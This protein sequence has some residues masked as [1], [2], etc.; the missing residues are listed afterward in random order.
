MWF[1]ASKYVVYCKYIGISDHT[2]SEPSRVKRVHIP[3][4]IPA[5]TWCSA[6]LTSCRRMSPSLPPL[7]RMCWFQS[8]QP[9]RSL[10]PPILLHGRT[11]EVRYSTSTTSLQ[12]CPYRISFEVATSHNWTLPA[13]SPTPN[14]FP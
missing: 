12:V 14:T 1:S 11:Q 8:R 3:L 13:L 10:C 2:G 9:T 5:H 6:T 7:A 4:D